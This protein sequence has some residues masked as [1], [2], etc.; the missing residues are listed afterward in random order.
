MPILAK[1]VRAIA[2]FVAS[3]SFGTANAQ[4]SA[5][6]DIVK[7]KTEVRTIVALYDLPGVSDVK[8]MKDMVNVALSYHGDNAFVREFIVRDAAPK[9]PATMTFKD[10]SLGPFAVQFPQCEGALFSISSNDGS[11][12]KWGEGANYTACGFP[13]DGG[14]RVSFYASLSSTNGG[15]TGILSGKTIGMAVL[16]AVGLLSDPVQFVEASLG[17]LESLMTEAGIGYSLVEMQPVL[18]SRQVAGD[19]LAKQKVAAEKRAADRGKRLVARTELNKLGIDAADRVRFI[20]AVQSGDEDV[21]ALFLEAG[22]IDAAV[23][24]REGKKPVDYA[25]NPAVRELLTAS[26]R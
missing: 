25:D 19:P 21:V 4:L 12:Q 16:K 2:A 23:A 24:D 7:T 3:T 6:S 10:F 9:Y 20:K 14:L 26:A 18:G 8:Q 17:K 22:A 13:Y 5:I 1:S 15:V 11:M